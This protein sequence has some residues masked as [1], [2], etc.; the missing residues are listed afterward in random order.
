MLPEGR[1]QGDR[2]KALDASDHLRRKSRHEDIGQDAIERLTPAGDTLEA[3]KKAI[4]KP[5]GMILLAGPAG[6]GR[7]TTAF[8]L[9]NLLNTAEKNIVTVED[10]VEYH[11]KR[12][13]QVEVNPKA[14]VIFA[15]ALRHILRQDPDIVMIGDIEGK[16]TAEIA[17]HASLAGRVVI[18]TIHMNS[19]VG[20]V[21]R[22]LDMGIEPYLVS[23]SIM[24]IVGQRLVQSYEADPAIIKE[25]GVKA[26]SMKNA[27]FSRGAGCAACKGTGLRG[28]IGIFEILLL[29]DEIR[30]MINS[31]ADSKAILDAARK[32]GFLPLRADGIRAV[33]AGRTTVEEVLQAAQMVED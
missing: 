5:S 29:D 9:I 4:K 24:C 21:S 22:L 19:A 20:T 25:L 10:P 26:A 3:L 12:V 8:T 14:G 1:G 11:I 23:S 31:R 13:N 18:S 28:R 16:E 33:L 2:H 17:M 30:A 32:K 6:S 27:V 15:S 7:T